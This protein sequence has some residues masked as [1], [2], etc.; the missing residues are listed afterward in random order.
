MKTRTSGFTLFELMVGIG[1]IGVLLSLA[2]PS[3]QSYGRNT[4]TI[5]AQNDLVTAMNYARSEAIR[6]ATP[7]LVC[8]TTN[9]TSCGGAGAW[10]T[11]WMAFIDANGNNA[12][13]NGEEVQ[14]RWQGPGAVDV[15]M[16]GN[17]GAVGFGPT[18]L[19]TVGGSSTFLMQSASCATGTP[20]RRNVSITSIGT[21]R[22]TKVACT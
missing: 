16:S 10:P 21:I 2:V 1:I 14:Q 12:Y 18:G 9:Y 17:V 13:D 8:A 7:V 5:A 20:G 19:A 6:R 11:G 4:R 3:F 22:N 15:V